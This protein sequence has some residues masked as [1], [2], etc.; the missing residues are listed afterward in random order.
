MCFAALYTPRPRPHVVEMLP[1]NIERLFL[2]QGGTVPVKNL[3]KN[4]YQKTL[5]KWLK[6]ILTYKASHFPRLK[7]VVIWQWKTV[8][9]D[10]AMGESLAWQELGEIW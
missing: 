9:K 3:N 1:S 6:E 10:D 8:P 5:T 4:L 7:E 2:C